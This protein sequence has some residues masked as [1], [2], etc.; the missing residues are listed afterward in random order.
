MT[1]GPFTGES[2]DHYFRWEF[3]DTFGGEANYSWVR[4][5]LIYAPHGPDESFSHEDR[6]RY[7]AR[8]CRAARKAA[9]LT[10]VRSKRSYYGDCVR[11]DQGC[12]VLFVDL[13]ECW[14]DGTPDEVAAAKADAVEA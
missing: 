8:V 5:G 2:A 13:G 1:N 7:E 10:G 6:Q 3:T 4:R 12:T 9:G 14:I 11:Y